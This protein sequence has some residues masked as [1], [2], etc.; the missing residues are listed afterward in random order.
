MKRILLIACFA[1]VLGWT[2][3]LTTEQFLERKFRF[4]T[5]KYLSS[6]GKSYQQGDLQTQHSPFMSRFL[7]ALR[8]EGGSDQ[9]LSLPEVLAV[10]GAPGLE[11]RLGSFGEDEPGSDFVFISNE[12]LRKTQKN[13]A[14]LICTDQYKDWEDLQKPI[15]D[16]K[17]L[18]ADLESLYDFQ[19]NLLENPSKAEV[20]GAILESTKREYNQDDNLLIFMAGHGYYDEVLRQ[21][22]LVLSESQK[23]DDSRDSF[24]AIQYL[25]KLLDN[26]P[27]RHTLVVA[28]GAMGFVPDPVNG[29][30]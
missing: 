5:R 19:V 22:Y 10:I 26:I 30:R 12:T 15:R 29:D 25:R 9:V 17:A 11:T 8:T 16:G 24:I 18:R 4:Q 6:A 7:Q 3:E 13:Y 14:L 28:D 20:I 2:Q 23:Q 21:G 27:I 1:P